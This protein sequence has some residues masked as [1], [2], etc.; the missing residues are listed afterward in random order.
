MPGRSPER[1][2]STILTYQEVRRRIGNGRSY[3]LLGNGFSIACDPVF[4]YGSLY[5]ELKGS[6]VVYHRATFAFTLEVTQGGVLAEGEQVP[7]PGFLSCS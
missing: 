5:G 1:S 2:D 6:G 4:R 3:L 7:V